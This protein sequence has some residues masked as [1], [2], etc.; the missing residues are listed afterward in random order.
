MSLSLRIVKIF[1]IF[2][3]AQSDIAIDCLG[4]AER[5]S[6]SCSKA[7]VALAFLTSKSKSIIIV[8]FRE[9][10]NDYTS[11]FI[12]LGRAVCI[13]EAIKGKNDPRFYKVFPFISSLLFQFSFVY[14]F[15]IA[16]SQN[17]QPMLSDT[18][19][20]LESVAAS[21]SS[22]E[23]AN[24]PSSEETTPHCHYNRKTNT[25]KGLYMEKL[26]SII[27]NFYFFVQKITYLPEFK[28]FYLF[29]S[30]GL[31]SLQIRNCIIV[32][33]CSYFL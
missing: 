7:K 5:T 4:W 18:M 12:L 10:L 15:Q 11:A 28:Q 14:L 23:C 32:I 9:L 24:S 29:H 17:F 13:Y 25:H 20:I 27:F 21:F 33:I 6:K 22:Q 1:T 31:S 19:S 16:E 2:S 26:E 8:F 3:R 30:I